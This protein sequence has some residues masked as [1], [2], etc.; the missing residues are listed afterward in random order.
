VAWASI[1]RCPDVVWWGRHGSDVD[2]VHPSSQHMDY[3]A[4]PKDRRRGLGSGLNSMYSEQGD[5]AGVKMA[6]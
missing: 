2:H 6:R 3:G 1:R 5:G 4:K